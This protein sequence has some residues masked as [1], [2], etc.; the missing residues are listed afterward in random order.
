MTKIAIQP[1]A[2]GSGTFT[3]TA[4]DSNDNRTFTL[5]DATGEVYTSGNILGTVSEDG[6]VPT[7]AII[8]RGS[9]ANG[10]FVRYADGTQ[11]SWIHNHDGGEVSNNS[12][13][14]IFRT[15]NQ[16][17]TFPVEF[18]EV[19]TVNITSRGFTAWSGNCRAIATNEI[20]QYRQFSSTANSNSVEVR[21]IAI[22]RW[23]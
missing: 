10:E 5:P 17:Y 23:F 8:E 9:N 13:G 21:I 18:S 16:S 15:N 22:G 19:P 11:I 14:N 7:G 20:S 12:S 6:G 2:S 4:P 3:L 1:N